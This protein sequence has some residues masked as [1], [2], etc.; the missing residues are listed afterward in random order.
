M[1]A[2]EIVS[3]HFATGCSVRQRPPTLPA[4]TKNGA[5]FIDAYSRMIILALYVSPQKD[6][7]VLLCGFGLVTTAILRIC[8][9][10]APSA[11]TEFHFT[12]VDEKLLTQAND[13]DA[14][15]A[16]KGSSTRTPWLTL[17]WLLLGRGCWQ[18]LLRSTG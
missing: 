13:L 5:L 11:E 17:T 15:I 10:P 9:A 14:K 18:E 2:A 6:R 3:G 4:H 16:K 8:A 12:A 1:S 7:A